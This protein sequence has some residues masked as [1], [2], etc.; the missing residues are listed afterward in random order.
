MKHTQTFESFL[1]EGALNYTQAMELGSLGDVVKNHVKSNYPE[2]YYGG[3]NNILGKYGKDIPGTSW[4]K[5][6][7]LAKDKGDKELEIA[8]SNYKDLANKY[9]VKTFESLSESKDEIIFSVDDEKLDQ[10]LNARFSRQLDFK[11]Y[12]SDSYYI[13]PRKDF[14]RFIDLADS[15][16]FDVDYENSENSVVIV[17]ESLVTEAATPDEFF[18]YYIAKTDAVVKDPKGKKITIPSGTVIYARGLG[19]WVSADGKILVGIEVL[20]GNTDFDVVN[21]STWPD[22]LNLT[23]EIEAWGRSTNDLIQKDPKNVQKII[24][25]RAKVIGDIRKMLK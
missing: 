16:G 18:D 5:L 24:D 4:K 12:K 8:I 14:D 10:M 3:P 22:T 23:D 9:K 1:N 7:K 17:E 21:N 20:K 2:L 25:A 11:N 6:E 13:L 19:R 15:S